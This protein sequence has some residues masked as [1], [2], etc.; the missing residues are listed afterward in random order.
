[1]MYRLATILMIGFVLIGR[2]ALAQPDQAQAASPSPSPSATTP[3]TPA[4]II[5]PTIS[6]D[7]TGS[8]AIDPDVLYQQ[9]LDALT[10]KIRPTLRPGASLRFG[11]VAP[12]PLAPL[13]AGAR[14]AVNVTV[15]I[16]GDPSRPLVSGITTVVVNNVDLPFATPKVL[17]LDDDPEYLQSEGLVFRGDVTADRPTRLYY[18]HSNLGVPRDLDVVLTSTVPSR[19]HIVASAGGPDLDVMSVGHEVSRDIVR[20][21]Q[22][23]EGIAVDVVPGVPFVVR[24]ALLLQGELVAGAVD[25]AVTSG[26]PVTVSVVASPAGGSPDPYLNGPRLAFDGRRRHGRFDIDGYGVISRTYTVGG[27]D[28]WVRYG[29]RTPTPANLDP[30]DTGQDLGDYGI[31]HRITFTLVNPTDTAQIIYFYE[32]PLGGP[33]RNTFF[34]DGQIKELGCARLPK[35]YLITA[36]Q[37]PP[38]STGV[39]TTLTMSDGGSYY[40]IEFGVSAI[41]PLPTTPPLGSPD[42]CSAPP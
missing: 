2:A 13:S 19:V 3:A 21:E 15:T 23:D 18:Y 38:H 40:P 31:V 33:V 37:L 34:I 30:N 12:W 5:P 25:L 39:S 26:G 11:T 36:Y 42:G 16:Q 6:L 27:P 32:K 10:R 41:Q 1:M 28:V 17:F 8:P 22:A 7:V 35:P 24:H 20:F 14:T 29:G 9:I 4:G